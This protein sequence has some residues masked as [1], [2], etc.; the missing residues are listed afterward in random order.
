MLTV[1]P[2]SKSR[3][4]VCPAGTVN[5]LMLTVVHLTALV[6]S[7]MD[8]IVPVHAVLLGA[9]LVT[10]TKAQAA[11]RLLKVA[12][13]ILYDRR[14]NAKDELSSEGFSLS[15]SPLLYVFGLSFFKRNLFQENH[16]DHAVKACN[17]HRIQTGD[18]RAKLTA[19]KSDP[20]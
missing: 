15:S 19:E 14:E 3:L 6:T 1:E 10:T 8:E 18:T 13:N 5:A 9:A 11:K 7:L 20:E 12:E 16:E 17:R 4:K 2:W